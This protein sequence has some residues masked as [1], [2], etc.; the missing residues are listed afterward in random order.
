MKKEATTIKTKVKIYKIKDSKELKE[1][2]NNFKKIKKL[3]Y[4]KSEKFNV[5]PDSGIERVLRAV[6]A[7]A[8]TLTE[9][10]INNCALGTTGGHTKASTTL[11]TETYRKNIS[12]VSHSGRYLYTTSY[13]LPGDC[14]GN[15]REEG[16]F[17]DGDGTGFV[18]T[19]YPLSLVDLTAA[20]GDKTTSEA[21][22][23]ERVFLFR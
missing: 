19:G 17:I 11:N 3:A 18:D 14:N 10:Q 1:A 15:F 2:G 6:A 4:F 22:L 23:I 13:Y 20:E 5:I 8:S 12:S 9:V 7:K 16:V 21:L